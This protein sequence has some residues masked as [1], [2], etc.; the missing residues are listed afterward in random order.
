MLTYLSF[1]CTFVE[2]YSYVIKTLVLDK[3]RFDRNCIDSFV[4]TFV[5]ALNAFVRALSGLQFQALI[6]TSGF[7]SKVNK[8]Y[9]TAG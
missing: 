3:C 1:K 5:R 4:I 9:F 2:I 7:W 6:S 8:N